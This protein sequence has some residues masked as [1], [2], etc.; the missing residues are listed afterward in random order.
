M[1]F[2]VASKSCAEGN[3]VAAEPDGAMLKPFGFDIIQSEASPIRRIVV[4]NNRRTSRRSDAQPKVSFDDIK[5][6]TWLVR[7]RPLLHKD[8]FDCMGN[9]MHTDTRVQ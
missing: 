5:R 9:D 6:R 2:Q 4:A 7:R 8:D 1:N 3:G